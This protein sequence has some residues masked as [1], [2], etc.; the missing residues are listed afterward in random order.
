MEAKRNVSADAKR[1]YWLWVSLGGILLV[2]A[3]AAV[4][5]ARKVGMGKDIFL[6][7]AGVTLLFGAACLPFLPE[8]RRTDDPVLLMLGAAILGGLMM[9]RLCLLPYP[10]ND[11]NSFLCH[12]VADLRAAPGL[13]GLGLSVGDYNVP[14]LYLL[15]LIAKTT[16]QDLYAIKL[17]SLAFDV[18]LA[19]FV[20][21]LVRRF[22]ERPAVGF[23]AFAA[24]LALP[25]VLL[26]GAYWGQCDSIYVSLLVGCLTLALEGRSR[27]A[28]LLL[29]LAFSFKLQTVF[30]VP[31]F[32]L[33]VMTNR[34]R[35]R[36]LWVLPA[37]FFATLLPA[38]LA[39]RSLADTLSI[40]VRQTGTYRHLVMN[41]PSFF[42]LFGTDN[43]FDV[44]NA[45]GLMLAGTATAALLAL[46]WQRRERLDEGVLVDAAL[47]FAI[48]M[49]FFL[50]R[51]HDRYFFLADLLSLVYA[52]RH[53]DRW[54]LPLLVVGASYTAYFHYL[55]GG[56][57]LID[58][59]YAALAMAAALVLTVYDLLKSTRSVRA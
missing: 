39:G 5:F 27:T 59:V 33:L 38:L 29:A 17:V 22:D 34:V 19:Y 41:A 3:C 50:P 13:T 44:L 12:W 32:L 6:P 36:D 10:S 18:L 11:Y 2:F 54:Y 56:G 37:G 58:P 51:M 48:A 16:S 23:T 42:R 24:T 28:C 52:F 30:F 1:T 7:V 31:L 46:L 49:P 47:A 57:E 40:Y 25:T 14:Y 55:F 15:L 4:L 9:A 45:V 20:M 26:N 53:R 43:N 35:L 8:K 21:R